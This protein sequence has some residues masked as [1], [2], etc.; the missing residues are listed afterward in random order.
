MIS[1]TVYTRP[2]GSD[3]SEKDEPNGSMDS[4]RQKRQRR[5]HSD[6]CPTKEKLFQVVSS[7]SELELYEAYAK[8]GPAQQDAHIL[9]HINV[10]NVLR[11]DVRITKDDVVSG[12]GV[13]AIEYLHPLYV[14]GIYTGLT[15]Q[16]AKHPLM[17]D[18]LYVM[19]SGLQSNPLFID[20]LCPI[21]GTKSHLSPCRYING[22]H[23]HDA[24][25]IA[26]ETEDGMP[27]YMVSKPI[28]KG[29]ELLVD[30]GDMHDTYA[31]RP[32]P[33][34]RKLDVTGNTD[35]TSATCTVLQARKR[36]KAPPR[37]LEHKS[38]I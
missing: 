6:R 8:L 5:A 22:A 10:I 24:N 9:A 2:S 32:T 34:T 1:T 15:T 35:K 31:K 14:V 25:I 18:S 21:V 20:S 11:K 27:F 33:R 30:Y 28:K 23:A 13:I 38:N 12:Y 37:E 36:Q 26:V 19:Q 7:K 4:N 3:V 16:F 29:D 17:E